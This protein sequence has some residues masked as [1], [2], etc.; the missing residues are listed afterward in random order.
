MKLII[1]KEYSEIKPYKWFSWYPVWTWKNQEH[2]ELCFIW[3]E[4]V[5]RTNGYKVKYR[6]Y[7]EEPKTNY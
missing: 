5:W 6:Y 2:N 1:E 7:L 4:R 3:L